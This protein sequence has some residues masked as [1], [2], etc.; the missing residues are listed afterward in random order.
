MI[1]QKCSLDK[2]IVLFSM[3]TRQNGIKK[4]KRHLL[5]KS[6]IKPGYC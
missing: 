1:L 6:K 2:M 4:I 3:W 5:T